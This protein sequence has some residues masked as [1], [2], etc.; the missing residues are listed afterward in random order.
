MPGTVLGPGVTGVDPGDVV[1]VLR[2]SQGGTEAG[3][4]TSEDK[5]QHT[6]AHLVKS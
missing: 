1:S 3:Y 2:S 5:D 4:E 6:K